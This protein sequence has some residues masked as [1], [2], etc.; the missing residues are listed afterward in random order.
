MLTYVNKCAYNVSLVNGL[1]SSAVSLFIYKYL[2]KNGHTESTCFPSLSHVRYFF[3]FSIAKFVGICTI[4][5]K[6]A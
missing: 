1:F 2:M 4:L 5:L 3:F 6:Q